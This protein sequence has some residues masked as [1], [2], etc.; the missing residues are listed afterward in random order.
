MLNLY[1]TSST[2]KTEEATP[3]KTAIPRQICRQG[4]YAKKFRIHL[5]EI[6]VMHYNA[7]GGR[8]WLSLIAST[9]EPGLLMYTNLIRIGKKALAR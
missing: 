4:S 6:V 8:I 7:F 5:T 2:D 9:R 1:A 3:E